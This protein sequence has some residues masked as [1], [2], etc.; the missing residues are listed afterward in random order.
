MSTRDM[1]AA[2]HSAR[3][4]DLAPPAAEVTKPGVAPGASGS[5]AISD[6]VASEVKG[7]LVYVDFHGARPRPQSIDPINFG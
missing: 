4:E 7:G 3:I 2:E 5:S 1:H 6:E